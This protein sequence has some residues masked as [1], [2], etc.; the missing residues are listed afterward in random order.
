MTD[1]EQERLGGDHGDSR[2]PS[3]AMVGIAYC[4]ECRTYVAVDH[5]TVRTSRDEAPET[6]CDA[7]L[8]ETT[9]VGGSDRTDPIVP[10]TGQATAFVTSRGD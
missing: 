9:R 8:A 7:C 10:H 5:V 6:I 1:R 4:T 3:T 2:S